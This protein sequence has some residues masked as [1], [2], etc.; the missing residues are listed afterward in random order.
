MKRRLLV[1]SALLPLAAAC[2]SPFDGG[3]VCPAVIAAAVNVTAQDSITGS[4]VTPGST[5]IVRD[6]A[7]AD[8]VTAQGLKRWWAWRTAAP[9]GTR[10]PFATPDT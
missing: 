4:V 1:F 7:Y 5:V 9:A 8:S 3:V 2:K 10:S 6:G